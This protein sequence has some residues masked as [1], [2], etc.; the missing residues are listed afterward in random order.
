MIAEFEENESL[1]EVYKWEI[2]VFMAIV[3]LTMG[4]FTFVWYT[5]KWVGLSFEKP[6]LELTNFMN[7]IDIQNMN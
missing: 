2:I 5:A 1:R 4:I 3:F 6:I 7:S